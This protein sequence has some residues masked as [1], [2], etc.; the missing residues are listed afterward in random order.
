MEEP[1]TNSGSCLSSKN[2]IH[3]RNNAVVYKLVDRENNNIYLGSTINIKER[4]IRHKKDKIRRPNNKLYN[5]IN[6]S[7]AD[8]IILQ[9][10][11]C[12]TRQDLQTIKILNALY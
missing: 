9:N 7:N 10:V 3:K 8:V 6:V 12:N 4:L 11:K 5:T 2:E 1:Q